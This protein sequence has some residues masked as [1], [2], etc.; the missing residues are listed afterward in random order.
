VSPYLWTS[1]TSFCFPLYDGDY[2]Q[3]AITHTDKIKMSL[4]TIELC[5]KTETYKVSKACLDHLAEQIFNCLSRTIFV[6]FLGHFCTVPESSFFYFLSHCNENHEH[7]R[8][9]F[10]DKKS[11][12]IK[13][14]LDISGNVRFM[15]PTNCELYIA[16]ILDPTVNFES[17]SIWKNVENSANPF[18]SFEFTC[19]FD[20][21][22]KKKKGEKMVILEKIDLDGQNYKII[23][24]LNNTVKR[25]S[26]SP[27]T[28]FRTVTSTRILLD[29]IAFSDKCSYTQDFLCTSKK[30]ETILISRNHNFQFVCNW[31]CALGAPAFFHPTLPLVFT[32]HEYSTFFKILLLKTASSVEAEQFPKL[33]IKFVYKKS[34]VWIEK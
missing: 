12:I 23:C 26:L 31:N 1:S 29:A 16:K 21:P 33:P 24:E 18:S 7:T 30:N 5:E 10:I 20:F 34:I 22:W 9:L 11:L 14:F 2:R 17:A 13:S 4:C 8:L 28:T 27:T 3:I 32:K 19:S 15:I 25:Y 6:K